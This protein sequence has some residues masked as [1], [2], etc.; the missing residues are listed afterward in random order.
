METMEGVAPRKATSTPRSLAAERMVD[1]S[2]HVVVGDVFDVVLVC[3]GGV[4]W[5][6][7]VDARAMKATIPH[8]QTGSSIRVALENCSARTYLRAHRLH[9]LEERRLPRIRLDGPD[10]LL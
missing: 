4:G 6:S 5:V 3:G 8:A 7:W 2:C 10:A 1:S 9:L